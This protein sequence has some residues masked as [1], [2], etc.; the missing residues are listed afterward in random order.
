MDTG[1][2]PDLLKK[3]NIIPVHK[4]EIGNCCKITDQFLCYLFL[5]KLLRKFCSIQYLNVYRKIT[6]FVKISL[7]FDHM[8]QF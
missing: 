6:Y 5:E 7:V 4:K 8:I 1:M 2:F 3:S